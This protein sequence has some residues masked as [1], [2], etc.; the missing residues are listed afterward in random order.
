MATYLRLPGVSAD[1]DEAA[2][3]GWSVEAGQKI[4]AGDVVATVETEKA[5]VDIECDQDGVVHALVVEAGTL[6]P[7]GDP[8]AVL[9][10]PDE[11]PAAGDALLAELGLGPASDAA[12]PAPEPAPPAAP[13]AQ[14]PAPVAPAPAEPAPAAPA[15]DA[16]AAPAA[17]AG[18]GANGGRIFAS[19]L[20]RRMARDAG[21]GLDQLDGTGPGGRIVRDDVL[22]AIAA[23]QSPAAATAAPAEAPE[24]PRPA[25]TCATRAA[26]APAEPPVAAT[27]ATGA[28]AVRT[29]AYGPYEEV[30]HSKLRRLVASRLQASKQEA[31]HFY[32]RARVRVDELLAL[33]ATVNASSPVRV[34]VNDFF[35]RAAARALVDVPEMNVV[36]TPDAVLRF[37][38]ADVSVAVASERGLVTPVVRGA[39][40]LSLGALSAAV[41]DLVARAG[42]GRLQQDELEGGA[43][44]V[45]NLGMYGVREFDA[46][47]NPPQVGILAVGAAVAEPV[48]VDGEVQVAT[49]VHL[50]LSVDHRP[51]DGVV[52]ARFLAR[53]T[54]IVENPLQ[55]LI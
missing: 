53:L 5:V 49:V 51:V 10:A 33:R 34:S 12:E 7:V 20:A 45:T 17:P 25:T 15:A 37:E 39:D 36:W 42:E 19:P 48:V 46:I 41:K 55:A 11:D 35:V 16:P 4:A 18:P 30:P 14:E 1:S 50:T 31:P 24:A 22:R 52:A 32:L 6:V 28:P 21:L 29:S 26:S 3:E 9:L 44:T 54:E 43:L 27:A 38:R 23:A 8:I 2:L 13:A 40:S 47:I